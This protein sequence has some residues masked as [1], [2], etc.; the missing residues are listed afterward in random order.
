MR[1]LSLR[2]DAAHRARLTCPKRVR[3]EIVD[4]FFFDRSEWLLAQNQEMIKLAPW[5]D[6]CGKVGEK[7]LY[8]GDM[9][10]LKDAVTVIKKP[11]VA[12]TPAEG[13]FVYYYWPEKMLAMREQARSQVYAAV[14]RHFDQQGEKVLLERAEI[15]SQM[16]ALKPK[17]IRFRNQKSRWGSCSASG[18]ISLNRRLIGAPLWVIDSVIVHEFA[19]LVHLNHSK[20]FW[21]LVARYSPTHDAAD[22]WLNENQFKLLR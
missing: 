19:H 9:L 13:P 20:K 1:S 12:V 16:M 5:F 21:D 8:L 17:R 2:L 15:I 7:Y 18:H 10:T 11:F 22:K 14:V 3:R 4:K 6:R